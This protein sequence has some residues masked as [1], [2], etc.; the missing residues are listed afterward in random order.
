MGNAAGISSEHFEKMRAEFEEKKGSLSDEELFNHM[1]AY[2]EGL[3]A[4]AAAAP[5]AAAEASAAPPVQ[6]S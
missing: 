2:Y 5:G 4:A 3:Q 6:A 1:K